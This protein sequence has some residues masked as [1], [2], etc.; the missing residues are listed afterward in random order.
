MINNLEWAAHILDSKDDFPL[1]AFFFCFIITNFRTEAEKAQND[2][3]MQ[4]H[5]KVKGRYQKLI[6]L[7][8]K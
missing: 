6:L 8:E 5:I 4:C 2:T 1:R 7:W 3:G